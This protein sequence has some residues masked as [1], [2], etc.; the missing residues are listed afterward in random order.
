MPAMGGVI[1]CQSNV[2]MFASIYVCI[3]VCNWIEYSS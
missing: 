3:Y 1:I 2:A